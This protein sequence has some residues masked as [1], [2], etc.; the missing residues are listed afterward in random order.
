M[1]P[2][3]AVALPAVPV[4]APMP[5]AG[6]PFA[7][8]ALAQMLAADP[9][10]GFLCRE[11]QASDVV[12][13]LGPNGAG[14]I[15][16]GAG[17]DSYVGS[18][19]S[20][21]RAAQDANPFGPA[22]AAILA[23]SRLF[24]HR[25]DPPAIPFTCNALDWRETVAPPGAPPPNLADLGELWFVGAGSVGSAVMYFLTL[26]TRDFSAALF[27]MD[28]VKVH[29]LDRSPVYSADDATR[30][31][32]KVHG[33][34]NYLRSVGVKDVIAEEVALHESR[35]WHGR[36][37]GHPDLIVSAAN[38]FNVRNFIEEGFPP[39]QLYATTGKNW[40]TALIRHVPMKDPC[41]LCLF[42]NESA[43]P[44]TQCATGKIPENSTKGEPGMDAAL[45][46]LSFAA[47]L[48]TA[49]EI[50]KLAHHGYPY[51][52][53]RVFLQTQPEPALTQAW[54]S[55]RPGCSCRIRSATVHRKMLTSSRY[56]GFCE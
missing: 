8:L 3:V 36:S 40:Q 56:P 9:E 39:L 17:W 25:L 55:H 20:P 52:A 35:L 50:T 14:Q 2:S 11:S 16:H 47:G 27:D 49:V 10:G 18:A 28:I 15:V 33:A 4:A 51:S 21:L 45:P 54:M 30:K 26:A 22:L 38:E 31:I 43:Q 1:T 53:N 5:W 44:A 37:P 19:P 32:K 6:Q 46:F 48:M 13:H 7:D 12:L 41:S 29:N 42:P 24:V 23:I 34:E